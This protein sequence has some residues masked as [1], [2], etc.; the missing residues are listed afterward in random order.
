MIYPSELKD[1]Y[2]QNLV[3]LNELKRELDPILIGITSK[4]DGFYVSNLKPIESL[5]QKIES[6]VFS[7]AN[8]VVDLFRATIVVPTK[9]DID[10]LKTELEKEFI[11]TKLIENRE[12]EPSNFV[13]DDIHLYIKYRPKLK[14]PGKEYLEKEFELQIKTFLQHAWA[15]AT[16]DILYKGKRL[17]WPSYRVAHQIKAMLEQ[18]DDILTQIEKTSDICSDNDYKKFK[19][20]NNIISLVEKKWDDITL[21]KDRIKLASNIQELLKI[22]KLKFNFLEEHLENTAFADLLNSKSIT[23]YQAILG[24]IIKVKKEDL[25]K[26]LKHYNRKI[27]LTESLKDVL[28]DIIDLEE[29]SIKI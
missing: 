17:S 2:N 3:I 18:S 12:K 4:F 6:G 22:C 25:I 7:S 11:I 19:E 20:L 24:I 5:I 28:L 10:N 13:Y 14:V 27:F 23:P 1:Y 21:P 26:G 8:L 29:L 9:K 15:K 16:R